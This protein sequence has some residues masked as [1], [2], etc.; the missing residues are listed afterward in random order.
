MI[1]LASKN[2]L[3]AINRIHNQ[4]IEQ[5]FQTAQIIPFST[6][7]RIKWFEEHSSHKYPVFVFEK[8]HEILAWSSISPYR[9]GRDA[10]NE[11]AEISYYVD[12]NHHNQGIGSQLM[13]CCLTQ[14]AELK[15]RIYFA[16]IIDGNEQS[17]ALLKKFGFEQ[18]GY[19]PEV[20]NFRGEKRGQFYM[21]K[22]VKNFNDQ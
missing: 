7:Q 13:E 21:G 11:V 6:Q 8:N 3:S 18:W 20:I 12:R 9:A 1:R 5:G 16:V 15:K 17:L 2:D 19:L 14:A 22:I 10:L 4:A